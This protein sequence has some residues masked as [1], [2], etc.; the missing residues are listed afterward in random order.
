MLPR[1]RCC[2]NRAHSRRYP[3]ARRR[4]P[5]RLPG[6]AQTCMVPDTR[7][8]GERHISVRCMPTHHAVALVSRAHVALQGINGACRVQACHAQP[9]RAPA[10]GGPPRA[11][12]ATSVSGL[13]C[14][15]SLDHGP[16]REAGEAVCQ[17]VA[18]R[19]CCDQAAGP[20]PAP[21]WQV[22]DMGSSVGTGW[23]RFRRRGP[24][25]W[26]LMLRRPG[27]LPCVST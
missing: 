1:G 6:C 18:S 15:W 23:D 7:R 3:E 25:H 21:R 14:V 4:I 12:D 11:G 2:P 20:R 10:N 17:R 26:A 16:A 27:V 9:A 24:V 19:R 13:C 22:V 8:A 5:R